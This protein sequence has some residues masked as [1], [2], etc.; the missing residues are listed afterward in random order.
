MPLILIADDDADYRA[1]IRNT[2]SNE[3]YT[4]IEATDGRRALAA[5]QTYH[6]DLALVDILMPFING[7]QLCQL[8]KAD[9]HL[10]S[11]KII[12]LTALRHHRDRPS[13][14]DVEYDDYIVK[15]F[16]PDTLR[17]TIVRLLSSRVR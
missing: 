15:P 12:V 6:P 7:L 5:M 10:R 2:L 8:I 3:A 1:L 14:R 9:P 16:L 4:F 13:G 17:A 11:A